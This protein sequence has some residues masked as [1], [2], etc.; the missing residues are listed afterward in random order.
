MHKWSQSHLLAWGGA[1][2]LDQRQS[3]CLEPTKPLI[4]APAL[5]N[6]TT[7]TNFMVFKISFFCILSTHTMQGLYNQINGAL[8]SYLE[9]RDSLAS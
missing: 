9:S 2:V 5:K 1:G 7:T 3:T 6:K 4:P 8:L